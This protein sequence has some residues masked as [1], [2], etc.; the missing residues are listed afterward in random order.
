[1]KQKNIDMFMKIAR[2]VAESSYGIRKKVGA[3]IT[4]D[5]TILSIGYNGTLPG[6]SNVMEDRVYMDSNTDPNEIFPYYDDK[7]HLPYKLVTKPNVIHA[8][9]NAFMKLARD[10]RS[11]NGSSMFLTLSPCVN[12]AQFIIGSGIKEV[13]YGEVYRDTSGIDLLKDYNIKTFYCGI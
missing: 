7:L 13:Y 11:A 8:E 2:T 9:M 10:G 3:L 4:N 1:M 5:D 6:A 12:C